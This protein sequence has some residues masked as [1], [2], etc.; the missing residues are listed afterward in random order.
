[1]HHFRV[2]HGP[3]RQ[4]TQGRQAWPQALPVIWPYNKLTMDCHRREISFQTHQLGREATRR[5]SVGVL[6]RVR[7]GSIMMSFMPGWPCQ[8]LTSFT[9]GMHVLVPVVLFSR[10]TIP[11][12]HILS[13]TFLVIS[14][15]SA[16]KNRAWGNRKILKRPK[17]M[18]KL[19]FRNLKLK[20]HEEYLISRTYF[21]LSKTWF[22]S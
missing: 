14:L 18:S 6:P 4:M 19:N 2:A 20:S 12:V 1:M 9:N 5:R 11:K 16:F 3:K 7:F 13:K 8:Y 15:L 22:S 17:S 21:V 10:H